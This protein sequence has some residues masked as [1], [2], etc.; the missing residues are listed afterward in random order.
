MEEKDN[1]SSKPADHKLSVFEIMG[2]SGWIALLV[3]IMIYF[4]PGDNGDSQ[5]L[6]AGHLKNPLPGKILDTLLFEKYD[7]LVQRQEVDF[8]MQFTELLERDEKSVDY[9]IRWYENVS[10]H[11]EQKEQL[12]LDSIVQYSPEPVSA[13]A[14]IKKLAFNRRLNEQRCYSTIC[15]D[16]L[17]IR[18]EIFESKKDCRRQYYRKIREL[19]PWFEE[20]VVWDMDHY[21]QAAGN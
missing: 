14:T 2:Y 10:L 21:R 17:K 20:A 5:I 13:R 19:I 4:L 18:K 1:S 8:L 11:Y 6:Y 9:I 16:L 7:H 15:L 3:A 12:M